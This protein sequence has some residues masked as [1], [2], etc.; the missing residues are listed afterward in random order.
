QGDDG[1]W[2]GDEYGENGD[3][4][5]T[6]W[7]LHLLRR[8]RAQPDD[9]SVRQAVARVRDG[10]VW[11]YFDDLPYFHGE[12]EEC[13]NGGVLALAVYFGRL[14]G[15]GE[16]GIR[17]AAGARVRSRSAS[18]IWVPGGRPAAKGAAVAAT[19][20]AITEARRSGEEY[21]LERS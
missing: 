20:P 15:G 18:L 10:V 9:P 4:R 12:V 14:G 5:G 13:V 16:R 17:G 2:G 7:T 6:H 8:L 21:L 19:P 1:Y 3:R 11:K